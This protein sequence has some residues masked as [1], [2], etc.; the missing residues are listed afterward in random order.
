MPETGGDTASARGSPSE[1]R[2][3][4]VLFVED[5]PIVR[6]SLAE[7][8]A[9]ETQYDVHTAGDGEEAIRFLA[10]TPCDVIVSDLTM[11]GLSG[12]R[13][14]QALQRAARNASLIVV[15]ANDSGTADGPGLSFP[16]VVSYLVKPL[17]RK[18]L[19]EAIANALSRMPGQSTS[20]C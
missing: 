4:R 8:L 1:P 20:A 14:V 12:C 18:A 11:P 19:L 15:S 17:R 13:L 16:G 2:R 3:R 10:V 6:Q 9:R 5:D 7:T